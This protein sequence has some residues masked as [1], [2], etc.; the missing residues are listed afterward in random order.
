MNSKIVSKKLTNVVILSIILV[1]G[2]ISLSF[3]SSFIINVQAQPS[4]YYDDGMHDNNNYYK[5]KDSNSKNISL[6]KLN[7]I[8]TNI[9]INGNN[10]GNVGI[11]NKGATEEY[12][13]VYSSGNE[14]YYD[15]HSKKDKGFDCTINNNNTNTNVASG[16]GN[17]TN[18]CE[19]CFEENLNSTQ[20]AT[21][22]TALEEGILALIE[23][24][25]IEV[26]SLEEYCNLLEEA[27]LAPGD[28]VVSLEFLVI[29]A[30][31]APDLETFEEIV[32]DLFD[33]LV[34]ALDIEIIIV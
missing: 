9:N 5:S 10:S 32:Q 15:G 24:D 2:T 3:S 6:N 7:C 20:I 12:L 4:Y 28:L 30:G 19:E 1:T 26:N 25:L 13:G 17:E 11:G 22:Q 31:L 34:E 21:L 27:E 14:G 23:G 33:C 16:A 8:N 18:A 29:D